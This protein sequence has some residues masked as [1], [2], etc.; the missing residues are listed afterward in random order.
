MTLICFFGAPLMR[1]ICSS[2]SK[3]LKRLDLLFGAW[4]ASEEGKR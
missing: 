1:P 2:P 3:V 4:F